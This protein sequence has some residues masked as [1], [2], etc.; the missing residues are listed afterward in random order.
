MSAMKA[1]TRQTPL[2]ASSYTVHT[3]GSGAPALLALHGFTGSG[4]DFAAL[5]SNL[6]GA[7]HCPDLPGHGATAVARPAPTEPAAAGIEACAAD[8]ALLAAELGLDQPVLLG[9]SLGGRTAL[10]LA[11]RRPA[12]ARGLVLIG[13]SPGLRDAAEQA[14]RRASDEAL[15]SA[16]ES[17]GTAAFMERWEDLPLLRSQLRMGHAPWQEFSAR[18]RAGDAHGLALSLRTMGTG[19]MPPLWDRLAELELPIL[20]VTGEEDVRYT[21]VARAMAARLPRAECSVVAAAGHS[22]HLERPPEVAEV[23]RAFVRSLG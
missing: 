11:C 10:T 19:S 6:G 23:V 1:T 5:A 12:F 21:E 22:P 7:M 14:A 2:G 4:L 18:R 15:A 20:L 13:A 3:F 9:Y 16:L 17:G 8:I